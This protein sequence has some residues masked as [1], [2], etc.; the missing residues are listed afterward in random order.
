MKMSRIRGFFSEINIKTQVFRFFKHNFLLKLLAVALSLAFWAGLVSQD[1]NI[2]REK[3]FENI[4]VNVSGDDTLKRNGLIVTTDLSENPIFVNFTASVPQMQFQSAKSTN[5]LP[6][7][8]LTSITEV[9]EI[10]IPIQTYSTATYGSVTNMQPPTAALTV[11]KYVTQYRVPVQYE[12]IGEFPNNLYGSEPYLDPRT[13]Q[14]SGPESIV[15]NVSKAIVQ[16]DASI[17]N[18]ASEGQVR[19]TLPFKL[20]NANGEE[21]RSNLLQVSSESVKISNIVVTQHL[22]SLK[23]FKLSTTGLIE[24]EIASGYY[25]RG[26]DITPSVVYIAGNMD[27]LKNIESVFSNEQ[28]NIDQRSTSFIK[29][30][31][32]NIPNEAVYASSKTAVVSVDIEPV[33]KSKTITDINYLVLGKNEAYLYDASNKKVEIRLKGPVNSINQLKANNLQVETD[34]SALGIGSHTL[35]LN[36]N[37]INTDIN[38]VELEVFPPT[39]TIAVSAK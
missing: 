38:D 29:N 39:L 31:S 26:I 35:N 16:I 30:I 21:I 15:N 4:R 6:R 22:Y 7:I 36:V 33:I 20:Y 34:V 17:Y 8:D 9:G 10:D 14:V 12:I 18:N 37:L 5:Y 28:L 32:L 19:N 25:I 27:L 2:T 11:D 3:F 13:I 24:G 1:P 23:S